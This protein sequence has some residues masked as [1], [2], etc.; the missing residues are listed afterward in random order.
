MALSLTYYVK[1]IFTSS[2][3]KDRPDFFL[4]YPKGT[5]AS[6][7]KLLRKVGSNQ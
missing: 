4:W 6:E 2:Y 1:N 5:P 7:K 3:G